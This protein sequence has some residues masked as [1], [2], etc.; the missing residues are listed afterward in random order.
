[1]TLTKDILKL[2]ISVNAPSYEQKRKGIVEWTRKQ[3]I[4][5]LNVLPEK[6]AQFVFLAFSGK[7]GD[8]TVVFKHVGTWQA[9]EPIYTY[10][11][12]RIKG[13]TSLSSRFWWGILD[14][15]KALRNRLTLVKKELSLSIQTIT[16]GK[17]VVR[18]LSIGSGSAR[19]VIETIAS[20]N[21]QWRTEVMLIDSDPTAIEFSKSLADQFHINYTTRFTGNFLYL[22]RDVTQFNPD[23]IELVGLLDYFED[24][25]AILFIKKVIRLLT[26]QGYLITGNI[27]PNLERPFITKGINWPMIYRTPEEL[28]NLLITAGFS[29]RSIRIE[30]EP[31]NVH[32][33]AVC[34]KLLDP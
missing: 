23:V 1:M 5:L 25:I 13:K 31:L 3:F 17:D 7:N 11:E 27:V 12:R 33:V 24:R 30:K 10:P 26:P 9:L 29:E 6:L 2:N 16:I 28:K 14:N 22:E 8:T 34:Q 18:I 15:T 32:M 20:F 4:K 21:G 19:S